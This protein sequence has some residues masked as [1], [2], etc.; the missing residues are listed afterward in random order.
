M[1]TNGALSEPS[2][3]SKTL[4][5][6]F[7]ISSLGVVGLLMS[8]AANAFQEIAIYSMTWRRTI[9]RF[10]KIPC[11]IHYTTR[12]IVEELKIWAKRF[13]ESTIN[14]QRGQ[15]HERRNP[16]VGLTRAK[17]SNIKFLSSRQNT[18]QPPRNVSKWMERRGVV[19]ARGEKETLTT[20]SEKR[21]WKCLA[22]ELNHDWWVWITPYG[23]KGF[24]I[25]MMRW[26]C[27]YLWRSGR[28]TSIH[29]CCCRWS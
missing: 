20:I 25:K 4:N 23:R 28:A 5:I 26:C 27:R 11:Y 16:T 10:L 18:V 8:A 22:T 2:F 19:C 29:N 14:G 3:F 1:L 24:V 7:S 12:S 15:E 21:F 6:C 17:S 9:L 13:Q